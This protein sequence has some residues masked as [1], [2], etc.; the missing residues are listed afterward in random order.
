MFDKAEEGAEVT[1]ITKKCSCGLFC[2]V[3]VS[4]WDSTVGHLSCECGISTTIDLE[5][6]QT[7]EGVK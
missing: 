2:H 4:E 5:K 1:V 3:K 7:T 6:Y